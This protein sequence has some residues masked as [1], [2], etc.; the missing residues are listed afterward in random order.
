MSK[1][2]FQNHIEE[3]S[4]EISQK[5]AMIMKLGLLRA[6]TF[7]GAVAFIFLHFRNDFPFALFISI[8]FIIV[9]GILVNIYR[10]RNHQLLLSKELKL[11]N[12]EEIERL[13]L[14]LKNFDS[15]VQYNVKEHPYQ[16]D[17][18]IL[19][20]HSLF[21]LVNRCV[22]PSSKQL[23][24]DWLSS[25][26]QVDEC[27]KRQKSAE[28]LATDFSLRQD[29]MAELRLAVKKKKKEAPDVS[30]KDLFHW[31][32]EVS[33]DYS[34]NLVIGLNTL[35]IIVGLMV[36]FFNQT[37]HWIYLPLILNGIFLARTVKKLKKETSGIDKAFYMIKSYE[38]AIKKIEKAS[39][40][41]V[42]LKDLRQKIVDEQASKAIQELSS[43]TQRN[44]NRVNMLY[45]VLDFTFILDAHLLHS[46][47][48]WK[49]QYGSRLRYWLDVVHEIEC[50][51]SLGAFSA[52]HPEYNYPTFSESIELKAKSLGH[53]L[54]DPNVV[55]KNDFVLSESEKLAV[56][57]GSNMSGK[58][59][60]ERT[61][62]IN[63]ALAFA[64]APVYAETFQTGIFQIFTSMRTRDNLEES[65]SSFYAE[66]KRIKQLLNLIEGQMPVFYL[67]DEILKGT[68]SN[69]RHIGA[70]ALIR[71]LVTKNGIGLVSTH[72]LE[73]GS[74][75]DQVNGVTN[76]SFNSQIDDQKI[77]FDYLLTKGIC[78]SFNAS[79]LMR[80][81]GI[82]D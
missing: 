2:S 80:N 30:A 78:K 36:L 39:F 10:S 32:S 72:D 64:G 41:S 26:A 29:L 15:G 28:E 70:E 8:G 51:A 37:Y 6:V 4:T 50:M 47:I 81:I 63:L 11:I 9:F 57:T 5:E 22:L 69:D 60:F 16:E 67:L 7:I 38:I 77:N 17:L 71:K 79:Q 3:L 74:L 13:N 1:K 65:T 55:V 21:Q 76:Y 73:L 58:S 23:L 18:D 20:N 24:A 25:P 27:I 52:A 44:D 68:N 48:K 82:I 75:E 31:A 62:G 45:A 12:E 43:I 35:M 40:K 59:T 46:L 54:I 19:G 34:K 33:S 66:L 61:L 53:P 49:K 42:K 14:N 56:I